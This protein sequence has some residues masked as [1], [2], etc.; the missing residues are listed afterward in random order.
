[1]NGVKPRKQNVI[2]L[3]EVENAELRADVKFL[4]DQNSILVEN[5]TRKMTNGNNEQSAESSLSKINGQRTLMP[6]VAN[7]IKHVYQFAN[8]HFELLKMTGKPSNNIG[9]GYF[10]IIEHCLK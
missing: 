4:M 1:M 6:D 10:R 5:I 7:L 3:I 8:Q 9:M 2:F